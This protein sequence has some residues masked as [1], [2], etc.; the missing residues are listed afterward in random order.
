MGF[1]KGLPGLNASSKSLEVIANNI[2][3]ANTYGAK[4]P[5]AEFAD[6]SATAL[7][8]SQNSVDIG[9]PV[10]AGGRAGGW[11][12]PKRG[13]ASLRSVNGPTIER[14]SSVPRRAAGRLTSSTASTA[15]I[16]SV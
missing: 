9:A 10:A 6:I 2:A 14:T 5:P 15:F 13:A 11:R 3:N 16:H 1:K 4:A 12:L 7:A 8:G